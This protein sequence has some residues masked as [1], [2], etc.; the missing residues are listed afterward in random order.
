M[1]EENVRVSIIGEDR[2]SGSFRK[3]GKNVKKSASDMEKAFKKIGSIAF[4]TLALRRITQVTEKA[5]KDF[6]DFE[7]SITKIATLVDNTSPI[8]GRFS[9]Q[10]EQ[11]SVQFGKST[12]EL[13]SAGFDIISA[14]ITNTSQ[15]L[16]VLTASTKLAVAGFADTAAS[17]SAV[18]TL[19]QNVSDQFESAADAADFLIKTQKIA[20]TTVGALAQNLGKVAGIAA[21][22]KINF[23]DL[24]AAFVVTQDTGLST[25]EVMTGLRAI[26]NGLKRPAAETEKSAEKLGL[27]LGA[28]ALEGEGFANTLIK[29]AKLHPD[30][31]K[32]II[33]NV[34]ADLT[35]AAVTQNLNRFMEARISITERTGE[36]NTQLAKATKTTAFQNAVL[37]QG[38]EALSR[39]MGKDVAPKMLQA[40]KN[41]LAL[42]EASLD[43]GDKLKELT[44]KVIQ[45]L[46]DKLDDWGTAIDKLIVFL[47]RI[48]LSI[49]KTSKE[50]R[51]LA[52]ESEEATTGLK[53]QGEQA[54]ETTKS[55][56]N[57]EEQLDVLQLSSQGFK[58]AFRELFRDSVDEV[59]SLADAIEQFQDSLKDALIDQ[60]ANTLIELAFAIIG[61]DLA[62]EQLSKGFNATKF[63]GFLQGGGILGALFGF[64]AKDDLNQA[65]EEEARQS[66]KVAG[67]LDDVADNLDKFAESKDRA[68]D[69]LE[70]LGKT[71]DLTSGGVLSS[72]LS[73][74]I[75]GT[76]G[77][78]LLSSANDLSRGLQSI[79]PIP[80]ATLESA[81]LLLGSL[82]SSTEQT[83]LLSESVL[84]VGESF[85]DMATQFIKSQLIM[86][87]TSLTTLAVSVAAGIA[88]AA[89]LAAAWAPAATLASIATFGAAA[90]A[91]T[92]AVI[93]GLGTVQAFVAASPAFSAGSGGPSLSFAPG[94][95]G[96]EIPRFGEGGI[97]TGPTVALIGEE[98]PEAIVPLN[99]SSPVGFGGESGLGSM[100]ININIQNAEITN[101]SNIEKL[102]RQISR[103]IGLELDR[104]GFTG[105]RI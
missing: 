38:F 99:E 40:R 4:V 15:A 44:E 23:N 12:R 43:L 35:L 100:E 89:A 80:D 14:G 69:N 62:L 52:D 94:S 83:G 63:G 42:A 6:S 85:I 57:L 92:A 53:N 70:D 56:E 101:P 65:K 61:V 95:L 79:E 76:V 84:Q 45:R 39:R 60:V 71:G 98:G 10:I 32:K 31:Q 29:L 68:M 27:A 1:G 82:E 19:M 8:F 30:L 87:A 58:D 59:T 17:T 75:G 16:D 51:E 104:P 37:D 55:L 48:G 91:G 20:R 105:V 49:R 21:S 3:A 47:V 22:A 36:V 26:I 90:A 86:L 50:Q 13:S 2:V 77:D 67:K 96:E 73:P 97:V 5:V 88:A 93:A 11:L 33:Q 46:L 41:L 64:R 72:N 78:Q 9:N 74:F 102:A 34:R 25:E 54:D 24:A 7:E 18:I 66:E 103:Q 81:E 28:S